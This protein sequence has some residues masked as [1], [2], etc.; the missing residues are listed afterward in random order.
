MECERSE[1]PNAC[2]RACALHLHTFDGV[3]TAFRELPDK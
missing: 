3:D 2:A 1:L